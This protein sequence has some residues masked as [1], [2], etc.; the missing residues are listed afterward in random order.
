[1]TETYIYGVKVNGNFEIYHKIADSQLGA[2]N[3]WNF[4][5]KKYFGDSIS[6]IIRD[7]SEDL[8]WNII[9]YNKMPIDE[10]ILLASTFDGAYLHV[11]NL[12]DFAL[13]IQTLSERGM[14]G[15]F[16]EHIRSIAEIFTNHDSEIIAWD[17]NPAD[18]F[19]WGDLN[20]KKNI[21][22][23]ENFNIFEIPPIKEYFQ[24]IALK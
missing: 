12:P 22:N 3:L 19:Y 1:M 8:I 24:S 11:R 14:V 2:L 6:S 10:K 15:N 5:A 17:H 7:E 13:A 16:E 9:N 21:S 18:H 20:V 23:Y 4:V